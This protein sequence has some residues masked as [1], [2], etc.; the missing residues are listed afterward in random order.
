MTS[1]TSF[2]NNCREN[3]KRRTWATL[4]MGL[5]FFISYIIIPVIIVN[6]IDITRNNLK[7]KISDFHSLMSYNGAF[8][9]FITILAILFAFQ[10]YS[11]LFSKKKMD[12]YISVPLS[13]KRRFLAIQVTSILTF[14]SFYLITGILGLLI[15]TSGGLSSP[16][17]IE[18]FFFSF[19]LNTLLFLAIYELSCIAVMMTGHIIVSFLALGVFSLYEIFARLLHYGYLN[20][21]YTHLFTQELDT[22]YSSPI[23]P[24]LKLVDYLSRNNIDYVLPT[25]FYLVNTFWLL[26]FCILFFIT[27]FVLYRKRPNEATDCALSFKKTKSVISICL[28]ILAS[29]ASGLFFYSLSYDKFGMAIFGIFLGAA[30]SFCL[31][32]IIYEFDIKALFKKWYTFVI[33][34]GFSLLYF[35]IIS[36]DFLGIDTYIP[37]ESKIV[38][39]SISSYCLPQIGNVEDVYY[40][41]SYSSWFDVI[42]KVSAKGSSDVTPFIQIA[43]TALEEENN[44]LQS[45]LDGSA[46]Y[47]YTICF[48]LENGRTIYRKYS[49]DL[50]S[51]ED[52]LTA[53]YE[54]EDYMLYTKN[55]IASYVSEHKDSEVYFSNGTYDIH[56]SK[57]KKEELL[58]AY[59]HDLSN[60][61]YVDNVLGIPLAQWIFENT[62]GDNFILPIYSNFSSSLSL[63]TLYNLTND[64]TLDASEIKQIDFYLYPLEPVIPESLTEIGN[65][66]Q[67]YVVEKEDYAIES[68]YLTVH[69]S[70]EIACILPHL[71]SSSLD[72]YPLVTNY[73]ISNYNYKKYRVEIYLYPKVGTIH[74][75]EL[76]HSHYN[77]FG[78][79]P[80]FLIPS[81]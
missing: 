55:R 36:Q 25:S 74:E 33:S 6:Q 68:I 75:T 57:D 1:N 13:T 47:P 35:F 2:L 76:Q 18:D 43:K 22:L 12:L 17:L 28:Q 10:G 53:I 81:E 70:D 5:F 26:A 27:A 32:N 46:L 29:L 42:E 20:S 4:L 21:F 48:E 37:E 39:A 23:Y 52:E 62:H 11:Y 61:S 72:Y 73:S 7:S 64:L 41:Y 44:D 9:F 8:L 65:V 24:Y 56:I 34:I 30:I 78:D 16:K 14:I 3:F 19:S 60:F 49:V 54:S 45:D 31:I 79:L 67:S 63:L 15:G 66:D 50:L 80:D 38:Q 69:N 58:E 71:R 59:Y 40:D 77:Y 51:I